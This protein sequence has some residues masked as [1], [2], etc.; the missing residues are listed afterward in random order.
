MVNTQEIKAE[1]VRKEHTQRTLAERM[2]MNKDTLNAKINGKRPMT[3]GDIVKMC[4]AL[5]VKD[6]RKVIELFLPELLTE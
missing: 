6:D 3:D 4:R 2:D 5:G 1:M